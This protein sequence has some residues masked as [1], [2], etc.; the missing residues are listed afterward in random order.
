MKEKETKKVLEA[1]FKSRDANEDID[2]DGYTNL[3]E[4]L[5]GSDPLESS[6]YPQPFPAWI[7]VIF[8][9]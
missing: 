8:E 1:I 6:D 3:E 2:G 4:K 5:L 9:N 7:N